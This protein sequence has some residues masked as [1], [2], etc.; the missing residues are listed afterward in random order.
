MVIMGKC[1]RCGHTQ[2]GTENGKTVDPLAEG[3]CANCDNGTFTV[4]EE[5]N[6]AALRHGTADVTVSARS[7]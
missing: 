6:A 7:D 3:G 1:T 5:D 4:V 2:P